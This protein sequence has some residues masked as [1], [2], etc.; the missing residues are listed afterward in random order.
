MLDE[1]H[2]NLPQEA[3]HP[4][5]YTLGRI[6]EHNIVIVCL[7]AG[8]IGTNSAAA[9]IGQMKSKFPSIQ[10]NLIPYAEADIRLGDMVISQS[11]YNGIALLE[12]P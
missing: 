7:S 3:N 2:D 9:T 5:L 10:Y 12:S 1:D 8:Y 6:G 11:H 4:N